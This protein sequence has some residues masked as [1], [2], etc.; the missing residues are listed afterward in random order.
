MFDVQGL[1]RSAA[2]SVVVLTLSVH[3]SAENPPKSQETKPTLDIGQRSKHTGQLSFGFGTNGA[4]STLTGVY[5]LSPGFYARYGLGANQGFSPGTQFSTSLTGN[6]G[7]GL[8]QY[9]L[10]VGSPSLF[11][12]GERIDI[13]AEVYVS[14]AP[15]Y[16]FSWLTPAAL[17]HDSLLDFGSSAFMGPWHQRA[18]HRDP[19]TEGKSWFLEFHHEQTTTTGTRGTRVTIGK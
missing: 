4:F 9:F 15:A 13:G 16:R 12:L 8:N 3:S 11:R 14:N 6:T 7:L 10:S 19:L 5:T 1:M 18:W 17:G 2:V